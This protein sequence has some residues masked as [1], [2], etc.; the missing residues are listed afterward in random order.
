MYYQPGLGQK[1]SRVLFGWSLV[2]VEVISYNTCISACAKN[3][4]WSYM[5]CIGQTLAR[6]LKTQTLPRLG[7]GLARPNANQQAGP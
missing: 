5:A 6:R 2:A 4:E 7:P 1:L 3:S